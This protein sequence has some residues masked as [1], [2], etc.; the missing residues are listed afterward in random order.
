VPAAAQ[1]VIVEMADEHMARYGGD[2]SHVTVALTAAGLR[3]PYWYDP[4]K[5][6]L[7]DAG[8][9][10]RRRYNQIFIRDREIINERLRSSRAYRVHGRSV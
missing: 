8:V 5:R 9:P 10:S 2:S 7:I 1:A 4:N 3:G 6:T